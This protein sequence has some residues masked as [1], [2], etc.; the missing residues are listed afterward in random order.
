[1][2]KTDKIKEFIKELEEDITFFEAAL[3][4]KEDSEM[5]QIIFGIEIRNTKRII[6]ALKILNE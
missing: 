5:A 4:D 3:A 6:K 2:K 1:M